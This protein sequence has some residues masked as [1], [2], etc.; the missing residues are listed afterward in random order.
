MTI[1]NLKFWAQLFGRF[2]LSLLASSASCWLLLLDAAV[3]DSPSILASAFLTQPFSASS[4]GNSIVLSYV[5][6]Q[7]FRPL[8]NRIVVSDVPGLPTSSWV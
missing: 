6:P 1:L 8:G 4:R 2:F 3:V 7:V 5:L